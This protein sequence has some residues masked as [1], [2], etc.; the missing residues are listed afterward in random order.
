MQPF[1]HGSAHSALR[2][3]T[4]SRAAAEN[5]VRSLV[6]YRMVAGGITSRL[7]VKVMVNG[8]KVVMDGSD[9]FRTSR[10][11]RPISAGWLSQEPRASHRT[12]DRPNTIAQVDVFR[13]VNNV[14]S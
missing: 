6:A 2:S 3:A 12:T 14:V 10:H 8:D 7:N 13:S 1:S 5:R 4:T 9:A 11:A